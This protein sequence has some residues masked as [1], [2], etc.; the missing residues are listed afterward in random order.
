MRYVLKEITTEEEFLETFGP[1]N[2]WM[3]S[4][5]D[6]SREIPRDSVKREQ[7]LKYEEDDQMD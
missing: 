3:L 4:P 5:A 7:L 1:W 2:S 6:L